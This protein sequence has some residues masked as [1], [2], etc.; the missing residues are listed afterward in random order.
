MEEATFMNNTKSNF[1]KWGWAMIIYC[2]IS[3]YMAAVL[4]TDTLNWYPAA[5]ASLRGWG[6]GFVNL[7]NTMA[8]L[9]G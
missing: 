6:E 2:G 8:G 7:C 5:F 9:G 1:G 3:Y 4:S